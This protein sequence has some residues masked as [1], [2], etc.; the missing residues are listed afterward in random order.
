MVAE[1]CRRRL[2]GLRDDSLRRIALLRMEGYTNEEIAERLG[3]GLRSVSRKIDLIRRTWL[4]E[5][6]A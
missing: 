4:G 5:D 3:C 2:D 1:E 6:E